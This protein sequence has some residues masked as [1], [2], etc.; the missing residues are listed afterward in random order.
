MKPKKKVEET[1]RRKLRFTAG[2]AW[3]DEVLADVLH[4]QQECTLTSTARYEPVPRRIT[5]RRPAVKLASV[6]ALIAVVVL[7]AGLW[8]RVTTPAYALDQ[9]VA[10]LQNVRFLHIQAYDEAGQ[11]KDERWIEIGMEGF[12]VRYRQQNPPSVLA[13]DRAAPSMVI[14]DGASTAVYRGDKKAVIIYDHKDMQY[15]WVG[16]LGKA[17][18]N[19]RQEGKILEED[20]QY[21]GLPA[22]KVWWPYMS[23]E[24][25][26]DPQTKL[27]IAIGDSELSYDEPPAGT[28]EITIPDG[29][30]V[31]D[32]R[33]GA[34]VTPVPQWLLD[35]ENAQANKGQ[36][37]RNGSLAFAQ[38]DYAEAVKQ[39]ELAQGYDSWAPFWLGSAYYHL[40]KYDPAIENYN[41]EFAI[42][43]QHGSDAK[44]SYCSYAR[45][46]AYARSGNRAA[47]EADFQ[48]CLPDMIRTLRIPSGGQMFEY[49]EN[50]MVRYGK[51]K[52]SDEAM[53][54][55]MV[56]R[57]RLISGQNFGY[58]PAGTPEQKE[59]AIATWEQWFSGGG[60]IQFTPDAVLL[61][62]PATENP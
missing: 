22:H 61:P 30:A 43:A 37:F 24:C 46:L 53:V 52:L 8:P 3:H 50:T 27:P 56:N 13:D 17:F 10:A 20:T 29:Y 33:P 58:D 9:T 38:G 44:L 18:E 49:A 41:K 59:A 60:P 40:G 21:K 19:L 31:L 36:A 16:E 7:V 32:K 57:L 35:E 42:W 55:K 5:M 6:A 4:A 28:F 11:I 12:Q 23:A 1:L 48:A 25:Y 51:G 45:G 2:P 26:I 47:A 39:F 34:P 62:V 54:I 15:Q 14:E